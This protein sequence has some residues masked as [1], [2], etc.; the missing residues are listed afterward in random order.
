LIKKRFSTIVTDSL[1]IFSARYQEYSLFFSPSGFALLVYYTGATIFLFGIWFL[2]IRLQCN[3]KW[4]IQNKNIH[5]S[6]WHHFESLECIQKSRAAEAINT[7]EKLVMLSSSVF[8]VRCFADEASRK[9]SFIKSWPNDC[10][11]SMI[12]LGSSKFQ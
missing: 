12:S 5:L 11:H 2:K 7:I 4:R 10:Q 9:I 8:L 6:S 1:L 3:D